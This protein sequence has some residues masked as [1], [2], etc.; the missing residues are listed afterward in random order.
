MIEVTSFINIVFL[1]LF[2][3]LGVIKWRTRC[4][5]VLFYEIILH[6]FVIFSLSLLIHEVIDVEG[7]KGAQMMWERWIYVLT[8]GCILWGLSFFFKESPPSQSHL[9]TDSTSFQKTASTSLKLERKILSLFIL[10][11]FV[12]VVSQEPLLLNFTSLLFIGL[13]SLLLFM[14]SPNPY[15]SKA[16]S[17]FSS[18]MCIA[19]GFLGWRF[20]CFLI[21]FVYHDLEFERFKIDLIIET[22]YILYV[23]LSFLFSIPLRTQ[24]DHPYSLKTQRIYFA[25]FLFLLNGIHLAC[26]YSAVETEERYLKSQ[27]F[28]EHRYIEYCARSFECK[29]KGNCEREGNRCIPFSSKDCERSIQ[30]KTH[31]LCSFDFFQKECIARKERDC[32]LSEKCRTEGKCF[33]I[34]KTCLEENACNPL[35]D[36]AHFGVCMYTDGQCKVRDE[37]DCHFAAACQ[38]NGTCAKREEDPLICW[39]K[40]DRHC[41]LSELCKEIGSCSFNGKE[42]VASQAEHC[43]FSNK[44]AESG[45][46]TL[47]NQVCS[48]QSDQDC[49]NSEGCERDGLCFAE[50]GFCTAKTH[51]DCQ[52]SRKCKEEGRCFLLNGACHVFGDLKCMPSRCAQDKRCAALFDDQFDCRTLE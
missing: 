51:L 44:C 47:K 33:V 20:C 28:Q 34:G 6:A 43:L 23:S 18:S 4:S 40:T 49:L 3:T 50:Y 36:C 52:E 2:L 1:Y 26:F 37:A 14:I 13:I 32:R 11:G 42:C 30:C 25:L 17:F 38:I 48:A 41:A 9:S 7:L 31:G 8:G 39:P 46:C 29:L 45:A 19:F 35:S 12:I 5:G 27:R 24:V 16:Q 10:V 15:L 21:G 22:Q